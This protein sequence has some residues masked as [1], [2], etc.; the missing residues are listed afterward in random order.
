M[1]THKPGE[2]VGHILLGIGI[3]TWG[4]NFGITKSA[5]A[6]LPPIPFAAIRFSVCGLLLLIA[7]YW[8]EKG[9]RIRSE[10]L[11]RVVAVGVMGLGFY[12]IL[13]SLGLNLTSATNSALILATQPLLGFLYL[14]LVKKE[15]MRRG[16][17][18]YM[19]LA[20]GGV[21]LVVL[22]PAAGLH[23]SV[24]ALA[25]DFLTLLAG[26][27]SAVFF[28][29]WSKPLL[30]TYSP[31]RLMSLCMTTASL[32]LWI[33]TFLSF[34]RITWVEVDIEAWW[35]LGYAI[36]FSGIVGHVFWYEGIERLGV[37]RS[38]VYLYFMPVCA[39]L[40]NYFFMGE[41]ILFQQVL[42]GALILLSVHRA[43]RG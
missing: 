21:A 43:L 13:W 33:A 38:L 23:I 28:S 6:S 3:L 27:C 17:Y 22:K 7:T 40:F 11:G 26:I 37:A 24:A 8:K 9:L 32:S 29:I 31:L 2:K 18:L 15:R 19:L 20:L 35:A 25:G 10:D 30:K 41:K 5:F 12:Q 14:D 42:G 4:A 39:V 36:A 16:Q 1:N 34:Q